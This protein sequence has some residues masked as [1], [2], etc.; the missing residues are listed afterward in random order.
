[1]GEQKKVNKEEVITVMNEHR[2]EFLKMLNCEI[3]DM[4]MVHHTCTMEF[5]VAH[6][7]CHSWNIIQG[8][9]ITAMLDSVSSHA[10]FTKDEKITNVFTL[11]LKVSFFAPSL[12]GKVKAVGRIEKSSYKTAFVSADLYNSAEERT[13][14]LTATAKIVYDQ[15]K[16]FHKT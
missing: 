12:A 15:S 9:F 11:E 7:F 6:Q 2:P 3:L 10:V 8:G 5:D 4:D 14:N 13:A 1:M 16:S